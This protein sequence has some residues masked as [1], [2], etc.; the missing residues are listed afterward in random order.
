MSARPVDNM[1]TPKS[2]LMVVLLNRLCLFSVILLGMATPLSAQQ[3]DVVENEAAVGI[4]LLIE[5]KAAAE[6]EQRAQTQAD[7]EKQA[8]D[9]ARSLE[10][11]QELLLRQQA[12]ENM[13]GELGIYDPAL[14]E[15][16]SDLAGFYNEIEDY[17]NA[18][19]LFTDALQVARI[20]SGLDSETQLPVLIRL[21]ELNRKLEAWQE[22]DDLH[23]LSLHINS[24]L[25]PL[26]DS[27]YLA[28][29]ETYGSWKLELLRDNLLQQNF[30]GLANDASDLSEF[31]ER[32]IVA[33]E[34]QPDVGVNNLLHLVSDKAQADLALARSVAS[35]PV[36]AFEG[37]ASRVI[38]QTRCQNVRTTSGTIVRQCYN[39]QVENPRYRQSQRD[40]KKSAMNRHTRDIVRS[41]E[42]LETIR[43]TT[44]E[45]SAAQ[46]RELDNQIV[47][48]QTQS[49]QL[50]RAG[51]R[52]L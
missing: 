18:V 20:S 46:L 38:T 50:Q 51:R 47:Q 6:A 43:A 14:L 49:D 5:V 33:I 22:V 45:L 32:I 28:Y 31:Y 27:R 21:I 17:E 11:N 41:I 40:A 15:A 35:T 13:R 8:R 12:L 29:V 52:L 36:S 4:D 7:E 39:V 16:Y 9:R 42:R 26:T 44:T 48:L 19:K 37:L 25:Y 23:A 2:S 1:R 3:P 30:R 10:I 34:D 24:R